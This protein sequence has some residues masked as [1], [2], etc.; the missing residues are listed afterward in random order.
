VSRYKVYGEQVTS[1]GIQSVIGT[2]GAVAVQTITNLSWVKEH[3]AKNV[4]IQMT[5]IVRV[6]RS[7]YLFCRGTVVTDKILFNQDKTKLSP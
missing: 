2:T 6:I 7:C 1:Q 5:F 3:F 4:T